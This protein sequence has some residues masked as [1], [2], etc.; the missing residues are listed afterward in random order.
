VVLQAGAGGQGGIPV[1]GGAPH[2]AARGPPA[3]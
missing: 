2:P 1:Q 3:E